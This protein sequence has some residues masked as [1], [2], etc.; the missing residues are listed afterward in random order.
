MKRTMTIAVY[1]W[2]AACVVVVLVTFFGNQYLTTTF[3]AVTGITVSPRYTGGEILRTVEH[4]AYRTVIRRPVF[5]GLLGE[6]EEGFIQI[7]WQPV[8]ALPAVIDEAVDVA[9]KGEA[10][11]AVRLDTVAGVGTLTPRHPAVVALETLVRVREGWVAR[12]TLHKAP[13]APPLLGH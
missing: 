11:F 12:I 1:A 6:R 8:T 13:G 7:E 3:A 5:D 4:G 2:A 9:D 10:A